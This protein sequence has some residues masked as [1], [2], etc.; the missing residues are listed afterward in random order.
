MWNLGEQIDDLLRHAVREILLVLLLAQIEKWQYRNRLICGVRVQRGSRTSSRLGRV[1]RHGHWSRQPEL[2]DDE[3]GERHG[4]YGD[5]RSVE[6][7]PRLL[8]DRPTWLHLDR[9]FEPL[10]RNF[11]HPCEQEHRGE[12]N[13]HQYDHYRR[14]G[15]PGPHSGFGPLSPHY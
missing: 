9:G 1:L 6:S 4:H 2:I 7:L 11:I 8:P 14:T 13:G 12:A 5:Y 10:R 15:W 3:V